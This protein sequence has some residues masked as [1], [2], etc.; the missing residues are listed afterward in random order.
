MLHFAGKMQFSNLQ[1]SPKE[2]D[3]IWLFCQKC[4]PIPQV[5]V[6]FDLGPLLA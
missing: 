1:D 2:K 5:R 4:V 3:K 6:L